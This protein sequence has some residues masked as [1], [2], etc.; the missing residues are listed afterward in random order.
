V[1][2]DCGEYLSYGKMLKNSESR[3]TRRLTDAKD[4]RRLWTGREPGPQ[5]CEDDSRFPP[6]NEAKV[7]S[8][9]PM[10]DDKFEA[11]K[12]PAGTTEA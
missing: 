6:R 2:A 11:M 4:A 1:V 9:E 7:E 10:N 8:S 3:P 5:I 12:M